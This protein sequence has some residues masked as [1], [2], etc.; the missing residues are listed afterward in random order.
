MSCEGINLRDYDKEPLIITSNNFLYI[1]YGFVFLCFI[2]AFFIWATFFSGI[3]DWSSGKFFEVLFQAL[4]TQGFRFLGMLLGF[5]V[6]NIWAFFDLIRKLRKPEKVYCYNDRIYWDKKNALIEISNIKDIKRSIFHTIYRVNDSE[7]IAIIGGILALTFLFVINLFLIPIK[8]CL[9][10]FSKFKFNLFS[11]IV[12]FD[13]T[14]GENVIDIYLIKKKDF[15]DLDT[16]LQ[17]R[18][19]LKIEN[20]EKRIYFR[21]K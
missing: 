6:A 11:N 9:S 5:V 20:L 2:D 17:D 15:I 1:M 21:R 14:N 8:I 19:G 16:Y 18:F 7:L 3:I 4:K 13:K 10:I 12:F